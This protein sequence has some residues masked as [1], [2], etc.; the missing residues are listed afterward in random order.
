M[1]AR[2]GWLVCLFWLSFVVAGWALSKTLLVLGC[3]W[4]VFCEFCVDLVKEMVEFCI[5]LVCQFG[6]CWCSVCARHGWLVCLLWLSFVMS[7]WIW[8]KTLFVLVCALVV[9]CDLGVDLVKD[10]VG[11]CV[12]FGCLL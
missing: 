5:G 6:N 2:S 9:F 12:C 11:A 10:M 8:S 1:C 3:A 4:V 7:G